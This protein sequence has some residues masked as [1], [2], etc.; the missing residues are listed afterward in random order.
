MDPQSQRIYSVF[1]VPPE[2]NPGL[3]NS[4]NW[5]NSLKAFTDEGKNKMSLLYYQLSYIGCWSSQLQNVLLISE[6]NTCYLIELKH[7]LFLLMKLTLHPVFPALVFH[8]HLGPISYD[9]HLASPSPSMY[10]NRCK[11]FH[12]VR[13][14]TVQNLSLLGLHNGGIF[15]LKSRS[16]WKFRAPVTLWSLNVPLKYTKYSICICRT[17][18]LCSKPEKSAN[19]WNVCCKIV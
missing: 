3:H 13:Y 14:S 9:G 16:L 7:Y 19:N 6:S 8:I 10:L 4:S 1:A 15:S 2:L 11:Y 12:V 17:I 18:F 5:W